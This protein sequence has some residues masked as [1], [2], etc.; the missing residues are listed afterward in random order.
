MAHTTVSRPRTNLPAGTVPTARHAQAFPVLSEKEEQDLVRR[1]K[2]SGDRAA[3]EQLV[4]SHLRLVPRIARKF[5]G[6]GINIEDLISEGHIGL[7]QSVERFKPEKGFRF[8]TYA[9]WWI[10]AAILNFILQ[11]WSIIK[12]GNS[13]G[14]KKLFFNL[15]R[16]KRQMSLEGE[17]F[18]SDADI[19]KLSEHFQVSRE[20]VIAMD[21]RLSAIDLSLEQP[22][23]DDDGSA[24]TLM[25]TI[26]SEDASPEETFASSQVENMRR[27]V[28]REG[29]T[30]LDE[31]ERDIVT[32]RYLTDRPKTLAALASVYGVTAERIRQIEAG[33]INKL[34][35]AIAP[36]A[37]ALAYGSA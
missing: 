25:D 22:V 16:A 9:R 1:W 5:S 18:L 13:A 7:M 31:R 2:N 32:K 14:K 37:S 35:S 34:K 21:S 6:Y 36:E 26:E 23:G 20:D 19:D 30:Q 29:L 10:K 17:R 11:T 4:G 28:L 24:L 27:Q 3:L 15:K 33:A 8:S 12:V